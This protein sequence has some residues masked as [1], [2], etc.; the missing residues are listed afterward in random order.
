MENQSKILINRSIE[1]DKNTTM[2]IDNWDPST[3]VHMTWP[4]K[5]FVVMAL[6][7]MGSWVRADEALSGLGSVVLPL[8]VLGG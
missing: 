5:P 3:C 1:V 2:V 6:Q 4:Q 8:K 7:D